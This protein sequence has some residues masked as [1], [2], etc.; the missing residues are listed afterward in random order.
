MARFEAGLSSELNVA[1]ARAQLANTETQV[2][3]LESH[4]RQGIYEIGVLVGQRPEDVVDELVMDAPVP[5]IPPQVPV[6]LPSELLKRRPDIRKCEKDL[7]AATAR[8]GV[9]TAA[10]F[11]SFSLT[12]TWGTASV[13]ASSVFNWGSRTWSIGPTITWPIFDAGKI[14]A[15]IKIQNA[16]TEA[17]LALY[18]KT[19]LQALSDVES[20][21]I[22]YIKEQERNRSLVVAVNANQRAFD[23]GE[24]LYSKGAGGLPQC[25]RQPEGSLHLAGCA[26]SEHLDHIHKYGGPFQVL[27]GRMGHSGQ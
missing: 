4:I 12:G 16:R 22:A 9:A 3:L 23:I 25:S 24:E 5:P 15:T 18:E 20:A 21:L 17:A 27:G 6:G 1:Q 26:R 7:A 13:D 10:L 11:P 2:P 8:I 19:V 14:R